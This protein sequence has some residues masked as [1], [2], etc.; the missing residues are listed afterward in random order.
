M[1]LYLYT[2]HIRL[3][4]PLCLDFVFICKIIKTFCFRNSDISEA[5]EDESVSRYRR[6]TGHDQGADVQPVHLRL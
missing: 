4:K 1:M 2:T 5:V 6:P 3:T